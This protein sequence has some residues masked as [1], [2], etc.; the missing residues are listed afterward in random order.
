MAEPPLESDIPWL[1]SRRFWVACL[2]LLTLVLVWS[3]RVLRGYLR[4]EPGVVAFVSLD[5]DLSVEPGRAM[6]V[7]VQARD[8]RDGAPLPA[9]A[10]AIGIHTG[11][12]TQLLLEG[13]TD[14]HG[15]WLAEVTLPEPLPDGLRELVAWLPGRSEATRVG[16]DLQRAP[17]SS[18]H[19]STDKPWYQPGQT[20]HARA[21]TLGS[22]QRPLAGQEVVFELLD[23]DETKIF[24]ETRKTSEFGIAH[25]DLPL[26]GEVR[27]GTY[28]VSVLSPRAYAVTHLEVKRY[29]LPKAKAELLLEP[30]QGETAT[31]TVRASF[32]FGRPLAGAAVKL[33]AASSEGALLGEGVT[34]ANGEHR[35]TVRTAAH[36]SKLVAV[37]QGEDAPPVQAT[38]PLAPRGDL[39]TLEAF[40]EAGVPVSG[41]DNLVYLVAGGR[42]GA[43]LAGEVRVEPGGHTARVGEKGLGTLSL[44]FEPNAPY[45]LTFTD[46]RGRRASTTLKL[47]VSSWQRPHELLLRT[48]RPVLP[49]GQRVPVRLL[50]RAERSCHGALSLWR[51][52]LLLATGQ[53]RVTGGAGE[54]TLTV[55]R[56]SGLV[57]L[58]AECFGAR[59][60][61][62]TGSRVALVSGHELTVSASFVEQPSP[63]GGTALLDVSVLSS[64]QPTRAA[65]GLSAVD[66]AFFLLADDRPD[67]LARFFRVEQLLRHGARSGYDDHFQSPADPRFDPAAPGVLDDPAAP[68][69]LTAIALAVASQRL[70]RLPSYYDAQDAARIPWEAKRRAHRLGGVAVLVALGLA[71]LAMGAVLAY[72]VRRVRRAAPM[73][74]VHPAEEQHFSRAMLRLGGLWVLGPWLPLVSVRVLVG[75]RALSRWRS[76]HVSDL[77]VAAVWLVTALGVAAAQLWAIG[78]SRRTAV[79]A[80][81]PALGRLLPLLPVAGLLVSGSLL[82]VL[83]TD[84]RVYERLL[85]RPIRFGMVLLGMVLLWQLTFGVLALV[86]RAALDVTTRGRRVWLLTSRAVLLG[87]PLTLVGLG[88][89]AHEDYL[90]GVAPP[91]EF[92]DE[93]NE[94]GSMGTRAKGEEGSMGRRYAVA[95]PAGG[96]RLDAPRVRSYFPETL[97][98]L[99]EV[100]T[101]ADGRMRLEIP[102]ADSITDYRVA[103]SAVSADGE[104]G[105]TALSLRVFQ[106]FFVD[107]SPPAELTV[108]DEVTVPVTVFNYLEQ[109]QRVSLSYEGDGLAV[110]PGAPAVFE[111][112]PSEVRTAALRVRAND[113]GERVLRISALG[114]TRSDAVERRVRVLPNGRV[115]RAV[116]GGVTSS[117]VSHALSIP[118]AAIEGGSAVVLTA[119]GGLLGQLGEGIEAALKRPYGCFEQTSSTTYP[120]LLVLEYLE[121]TRGKS[122]E[123][124]QRAR[125]LVD[126]GHQRLLTFEAPGGGFG[127]FDGG[128]AEVTLSA[129][130]L[131]QFTDLARVRPVDPRVLERTRAFV[132]GLQAS[133]G[134]WQDWR[135]QREAT[136]AY[137][138]W[139]VAESKERDPRLDKALA[140]LEAAPRPEQSYDLALRASAFVAAGRRDAAGPL[141]D[142][143]LPRASRQGARVSWSSDGESVLQARGSSLDVELTAMI[144]DLLSLLQREPE[145]RRGAL[146]W[147]LGQRGGDGLW[148]T[149]AA[150]VAAMRALLRDAS[151]SKLVDGALAVR[152]SDAHIGSLS[153]KQTGQG[154]RQTL[155]LTPFIGAGD[156]AVHLDPAGAEIAYQL[157]STHHLPWS[158]APPQQPGDGL[159]FKVDYAPRS[160]TV[161]QL[162]QCRVD[163]GCEREQ[164]CPMPL[165]EIGVPPGFDVVDDDL[166]RLRRAGTIR[167]YDAHS[168]K[169]TLYLW[170]VERG[171][172]ARITFRLRPHLPL[173]G[174]APSSVAYL[175]YQPELRAELP[176]SSVLVRP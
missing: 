57:E 156:S 47:R 39:P 98:W 23:P 35:F 107:F 133:D 125:S 5:A 166:E 96:P 88:L 49:A 76:D 105:S 102:A 137:V 123:L 42:G 110:L 89:L 70:T 155:E 172:P 79:G 4:G 118:A 81:Y 111:L 113:V 75:E 13:R 77:T 27:L 21:L 50:T 60:E 38:A 19:L 116:H 92:E 121:R 112:G 11:E 151:P 72:G 176:P 85:E 97:L 143:L 64:G 169:V 78:S 142:A 73:P 108:G 94:E 131:R 101:H 91:H 167:R 159:F 34:D 100:V 170:S 134:A 17:R 162:V 83:L 9:E 149:T 129:Y 157:V 147:L 119:Y 153:V 71:G 8:L 25:V 135:G 20:I 46:E 164:P 150:T 174:V 109:R 45:T 87:L 36:L 14:P 80:R 3:G 43:A 90:R 154:A 128:K 68:E 29:L 66:E 1:G 106:E 84:G 152:V 65:L 62:W 54:I 140:F 59:G 161:G 126:E 32:V 28:Q 6:K 148:S 2:V 82:A 33:H 175:Y 63:P 10:A 69:D 58:R 24:R 124:A 56:V 139:A 41:V 51:G 74:S 52:P 115:V 160:A 146:T 158:S 104:V 12:E 16:L 31:G 136:T 93:R 18:T 44:R 7:R 127:W 132:Y 26:A 95:G 117:A 15:E 40:V 86:R 22:D 48:A 67:Q 130:A 37:V 122:P 165:L 141:L 171:Q 103:L 173:R 144:A 55:P 53:G 114:A 168:S 145:L 30:Q 138:A 120:N 99:P 163:F 61:R